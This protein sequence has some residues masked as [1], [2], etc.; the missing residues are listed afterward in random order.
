VHDLQDG[1]WIGYL[2]SLTPYTHN[3]RQHSAI[4]DIH[5]LQFTVTHALGFSV[6]TSRILATDLKQSHCHFKTHEV[7][8]SQSNSF[9]AIIL[10]L[11][12][13]L[14]RSS[15]PGTLGSRKATN[16]FQTELFFIT[17]LHGPLRKQRLY[18][19]EGVFTAPIVAC[20]FVPAGMCL[21]S[22][23]LSMNT[24]SDFTIPAFGRHVTI[25]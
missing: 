3:Y 18:C 11:P 9:L 25:S 2:D 19:W 6:F 15:Y 22:R 21:P 20:V 14:H 12:I 17:T 23:C 5:T 8:I 24:Y 7:F 16:S 10:Q 1:F 13:P 4:V